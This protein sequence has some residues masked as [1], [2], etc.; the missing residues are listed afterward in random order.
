M[1]F[2]SVK[3][4]ERMN[5]WSTTSV[6]SEPASSR[7]LRSISSACSSGTSRSAA[8]GTHYA[9]L[10]AVMRRAAVIPLLLGLVPRLPVPDSVLE[11]LAGIVVGPAVLGWVSQ[12][13][14]IAVLSRLGV[15]FLLFLAGLE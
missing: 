8:E 9:D 13:E 15:A 10:L 5:S 6:T 3:Y 14:V 11:I 2:G 1:P 12:D 7:R 4:T